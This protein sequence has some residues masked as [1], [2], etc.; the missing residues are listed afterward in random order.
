MQKL[1][2][3]KLGWVFSIFGAIAFV[4]DYVWYYFVDAALRADYL[5]LMKM[6]FFGFGGMN[7]NS[8]IVGLVQAFIW[9]WIVAWVFGAIWNRVNKG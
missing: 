8:F 7:A 1:N 6:C 4:A 5:K 2:I 3:N 9:G